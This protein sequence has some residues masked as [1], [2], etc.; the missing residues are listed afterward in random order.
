MLRIT[1]A[2][3][4]PE[5]E[6]EKRFSPSS[7]P[8]GQNVN[9]VS[10]RVEL[11]FDLEATTALPAWAKNRL[12]TLERRRI[13]RAGVFRIVCQVHR[14]QARNLAEARERLTTAIRAALVRPPRRIYTKPTRASR[15]R[16]LEVKRRR[17][18]IKQ[19]RKRVKDEE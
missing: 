11:R 14:E 3:S 9:R 12:R 2:I 1:D 7:G 19:D 6:I 5:E 4:I 13:T 10:T 18:R 8:G 17:S 15:A 16:R